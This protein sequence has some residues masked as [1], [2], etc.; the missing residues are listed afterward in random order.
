LNR[1][2]FYPAGCY[3]TFIQWLCN[4]TDISSPNDLPFHVD[5]N[6]H[7]YV[8]ADQYKL[9]IS[10]QCADQFVST[11]NS[12]V[13]S[14]VWR[15]DHNGKLFNKDNIQ[16]GYR[17]VSSYHLD[18]F[19][20]KNV[21]ILLIYPTE[22]SKIWWYHNM[23]KKVWFS[24]EMF[25]KKIRHQ[26]EKMSWLTCKDVTDRTRLQM[27]YYAQR[28]WYQQIISKFN[29]SDVN[30]LTLAQLRKI[31][32]HA[33]HEELFDSLSHWSQLHNDFPDIKFITLD[34]FRDNF[35]TT[36]LDI[37]NFFNIDTALKN[38]I[39]YIHGEW[40]SLQTTMHR[41]AAHKTIINCVVNAQAYD[42]SNLNFDLFDE[43]YLLSVLKF[44]HGIDLAADAID[45]L[46]TNTQSL[47][48]LA[49]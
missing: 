12:T 31:M 19:Y 39:D 10:E 43:A 8:L 22:T 25:D 18:K 32:A 17:L 7:Q 29:C 26:H 11:N 36:V 37:F 35:K 34:D 44:Q 40:Q 38:K 30:D 20:D 3:G 42:W 23:Y 2:I 48:E 28:A 13:V 33:L 47:L 1:L 5:G 15:L 24:P 16:D 41:D 49:N 21:K 14:A 46:P 45:K 27:N 9:L 4:T 6:S